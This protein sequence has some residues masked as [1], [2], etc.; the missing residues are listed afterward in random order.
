[1]RSRP[2]TLVLAASLLLAA[3]GR[4]SGNSASPSSASPTPTGTPSATVAPCSPSEVSTPSPGPDGKPAIVVNKPGPCQDVTTPVTVAGTADVFE[5]VVSIQVLDA[6]GNQ[7][8][9]VNVMASCGTGCRGT[10]RAL[11]S[12]YSPTR[13]NGTIKVY[14][15]SAKNGQPINVVS[16]PVVLV[17]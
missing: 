2:L 13:Q 17:P 1:M 16:I 4:S 12:F 14:E 3:C 9:A 5:A 10:Y 15:V 6:N 8:S 7:L 11:V